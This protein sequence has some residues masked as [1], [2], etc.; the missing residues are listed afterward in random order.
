MTKGLTQIIDIPQEVEKTR[1]NDY[2]SFCPP[3]KLFCP[4]LSKREP[5]ILRPDFY[6]INF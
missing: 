2:K 6:L 3:N 4:P 5:L 1:I